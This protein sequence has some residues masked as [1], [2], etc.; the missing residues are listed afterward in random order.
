M[1]SIILLTANPQLATKINIVALPKLAT[2]I[3]QSA[4]SAGIWGRTDYLTTKVS[5]V[6][7]TCADYLGINKVV[8]AISNHRLVNFADATSNQNTFEVIDWK[9]VN[10]QV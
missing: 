2:T 5:E 9:K 10:S 3:E 7:N 6:A 4:K 1:S 8:H